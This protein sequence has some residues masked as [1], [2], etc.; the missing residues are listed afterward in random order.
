[1]QKDKKVTIYPLHPGYLAILSSGENMIQIMD[2][3]SDCVDVL[4][5]TSKFSVFCFF[6]TIFNCFTFHDSKANA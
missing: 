2:T 3:L 6:K 5:L 4:S 1:M